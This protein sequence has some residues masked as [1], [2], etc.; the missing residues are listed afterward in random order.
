[1]KHQ[2]NAILLGAIQQRLVHNARVLNPPTGIGTRVLRLKNQS[3]LQMKMDNTRALMS[4]HWYHLRVDRHPPR[5]WKIGIMGNTQSAHCVARR[6]G[7][8]P[9][10]PDVDMPS[11]HKPF[12]KGE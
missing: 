7:I 12:I 5:I 1:V 4:I 9:D 2:N 8:N 6:F 11:S 3:R 10:C